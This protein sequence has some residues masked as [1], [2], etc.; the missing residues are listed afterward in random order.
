M[1]LTLPAMMRR[2]SAREDAARPPASRRSR[3]PARRLWATGLIA[4]VVI[5]VIGT[6]A[7]GI[8]IS[9]QQSRTRLLNT[10]R[11]RGTTSA[12]FVS[13]FLAQQAHRELVAADRALA[14]PHV[15]PER[16]RLLVAVFGSSA[17][18]LLDSAGR[19]LDVAPGD[20][21]LL[22]KQ[23]AY[24]Y[25]HLAAAERGRIAVSGV[26]PSAVRGV[27]VAA[28]AVPFSTPGGRRV[29]SAAYSTSGSTLGAFVDDTVPYGEH[30][31]YLVDAAGNLVAASPKTDRRSLSEVDPALARSS[32][33]GSLGAVGGAGPARTFTAAPVRGTSWRLLIAIPDSRLYASIGGW[34]QRI[35]WLV[36]ALVTLL[37]VTLGLVVA[38]LLGLSERLA[39]SARTDP[40]TG[41][42]N[43][44]AVTEHLA[45]AVAHARRTGEPLSVLMIDL[46]RFKQTNDQFGHRAGDR[47]LCAAADCLR[48][49]L[50]GEDVYGRWGGDEFVVLVPGASEADADAAAER[51]QRAAGAVDLG[52]I[53]LPDGVQ[54]SVGVAT[55][56]HTTPDEIIHAADVALYAVKAA[57]PQAVAHAV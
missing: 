43:R 41:L 14:A 42:I 35:P 37:A 52:D 16:F 34:S 32:A 12:T 36:F 45:R 17:A 44:R 3:A 27:P 5:G 1:R 19:V 56:A 11:M 7:G 51:L 22:G 8:V 20:P 31:V 18:V 53:G 54:M 55:A 2:R 25:P 30:D 57:R 29:F 9:Q 40:L 10:F 23:I 15:S 46:D 48:E 28:V 39:R 6:L 49:V 47:V 24:R 38:R 13:T 26:V 21:A 4:V 33:R 50:R